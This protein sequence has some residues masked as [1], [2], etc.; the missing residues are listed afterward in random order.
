MF[1]L[2]LQSRLYIIGVSIVSCHHGNCSIEIQ[3][4]VLRNKRISI[5]QGKVAI[6]KA[7]FSIAMDWSQMDL[8]TDPSRG[9]LGVWSCVVAEE[10]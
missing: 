9:R 1:V 5:T 3:K 8:K 4:T 10:I 7:V 6:F 2:L